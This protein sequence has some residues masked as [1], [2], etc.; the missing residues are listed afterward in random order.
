MR[1][2]LLGRQPDLAHA[3]APFFGEGDGA[4][5]IFRLVFGAL[6]NA[7]DAIWHLIKL[8]AR[9]VV[10]FWDEWTDYFWEDEGWKEAIFDLMGDKGGDP[11]IWD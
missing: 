5:Y 8:G 2:D 4:F 11:H 9:G 1:D 6:E 3:Q 7:D 10:F